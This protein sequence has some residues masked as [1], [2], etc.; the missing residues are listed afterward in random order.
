[1]YKVKAYADG[2]IQKQGYDTALKIARRCAV[3]TKPA[4][5]QNLPQGNPA[6]DIPPLFTF[7]ETRRLNNFWKAVRTEILKKKAPGSIAV[8]YGAN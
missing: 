8:G 5:Y 1:M 6:K 3:D 4:N 7:E 2:L